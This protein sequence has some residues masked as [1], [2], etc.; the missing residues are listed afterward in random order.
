MADHCG[1][2]VTVLGPNRWAYSWSG[3]IM[4]AHTY[5]DWSTL[6]DKNL[7]AQ[8]LEQ[9]AGILNELDLDVWVTFARETSLTPDPCLDIILG[10]GMTWHSAFIVS[11]S[12]ERIAIVGRFD[13]DNVRGLD[14][15]SQ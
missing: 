9:A 6:M 12:G 7:V 3:S 4:Q 11:R 1:V 5:P 15:Y 8:K 10:L 2:F 13:A 14:A